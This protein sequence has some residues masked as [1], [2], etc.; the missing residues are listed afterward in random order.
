MTRPTATPNDSAPRSRLRRVGIGLAVI[1]LLGG[2]IG[3]VVWEWRAAAARGRR[4]AAL[5]LVQ[6]DRF[7]D[8]EPLL[9]E[10]LARNPHDGEILRALALRHLAGGNPADAE[11]ALTRWCEAEPRNPKPLLLR[12]DLCNRLG[13][14]QA[15][16]QDGLRLLELE[17]E[18]D[19]VARGVVA[20]LMAAGRL[21]DAEQLARAGLHKRP[22]DTEGR[23]LLAR[24]HHLRGQRE[25]A[26]G[27]V[28]AVLTQQ[29]D[30]APAL[31][32]RG[33][34]T[35]EM[36]RPQQAI[37][38]LRQALARL[39]PGRDQQAGRY[40]L[41]LALTECGRG[42]EA[43]TVLRQFR[44]HEEADRLRSDAELLPQQQELQLRAAAALLETGRPETA[45]GLLTR[46]VDRHPDCKPA[47]RML[48][49]YYHRQG[50]SSLAERHQRLAT[51]P[52]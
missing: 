35:R 16:L 51:S 50:Q 33:I 48:A 18:N 23:I 32:L 15:A 29:S 43:E 49:D 46:L 28:D 12:M 25:A 13:R 41:A 21:D 7:A 17:P 38:P 5:A 14:R 1:V 30:H 44:R 34:L 2:V 27:V 9:Q 47:H 36:G 40:H 24:I 37:E 8:A 19:T 52:P 39:P 3:Y 11:A 31:L 4:M 10:A 26:A 20:L 45:V 22:R 42:D 6:A